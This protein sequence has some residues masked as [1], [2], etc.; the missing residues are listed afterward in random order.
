MTIL[1]N[2]AWLNMTLAA[3]CY[4]HIDTCIMMQFAPQQTTFLPST[5]QQVQPLSKATNSNA[6]MRSS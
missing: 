3:G 5:N 1:G 2:L 4:K 6:R